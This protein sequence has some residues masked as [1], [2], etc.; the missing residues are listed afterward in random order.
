MAKR[1]KS[2]LPKTRS[3]SEW[4]AMFRSIDTRYETQQRNHAL[5]YLVWITG[6]RVSE[7]LSLTMA[8][9]DFALEKVTVTDGKS[10][11][12]VIPFP[13]TT[14]KRQALLDT[15]ERWLAIRETWNPSTNY[16]FVTKTG[17]QMRPSAVR[18]SMALYGERAS[19]GHVTPH[20][21]RHSCATE[22]LANGASPISVSRV[23][24]HRHLSTT[25]DVY[26]WASDQHAAEAMSKR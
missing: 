8:D 5:L 25:L 13:S 19:I 21:L 15:L 18:R 16:L 3:E 4:D 11:A 17:Q 24:G 1:K 14:E 7:A 26:A 22:L 23:L 6:L 20:M 9:V 2:V 12:R 10:G